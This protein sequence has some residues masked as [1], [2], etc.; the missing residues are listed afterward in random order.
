MLYPFTHQLHVFD[1]R[2]ARVI[3]EIEA[4]AH[5]VPSEDDPGEWEIEAFE[6]KDIVE[7]EW[8]TVLKDNP[9][10]RVFLSDL[11]T[12]SRQ[13]EIDSEWIAHRNAEGDAALYGQEA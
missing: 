11:K 9:W 13:T 7:D 6:V 1:G 10:F 12:R 5:V 4:Q 8:V 3:A 2:R